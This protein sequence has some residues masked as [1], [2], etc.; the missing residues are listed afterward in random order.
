MDRIAHV[1]VHHSKRILALTAIITLIAVGM[2]F[3]MEFNADIAGSILESNEVGREFVALTEKYATSDPI[4]VIIS[5]PE[6]ERFDEPGDLALIAEAREEIGDLPNVDFA[7]SIVPEFNPLTGAPLSPESVAALPEGAVGQLIAANPLSDVFLSADGRHSLLMVTPGEAS[8]EAAQEVTEWAEGQ[9][10]ETVLSGNPIVF[11][12]VLDLISLFLLVI[13][14]AVIL[15]LLLVFYINIGNPRLAGLSIFPAIIGSLWTF[16]LI[17]GLGREVDLLTVIVPIFV[18]VMGS[19]DGL[20]FVTHFQQAEASDP[21]EKVSNALR[22]VGIPMILTTIS[23]A[24]GFLSLLATDVGPIRQLGLFTAIGI[25]FAGIVSFFSLPALIAHLDIASGEAKALIGPRLITGVKRLVSSR[26]PAMVLAL[27]LV[28]FSAVFIPQLDVDSDQLFFYKDDDPVR[29]AFERTEELFGGATPLMGEF[30]FDPSQGPGQLAEINATTEELEALPGVRRVI[31]AAALADA[32]PPEQVE[33]ILSGE[34][35]SPI[36]GLVSEDGLRFMLLPEDF[37]TDELRQWLDYAE[38]SDVVTALTGMPVV[39][40][41]I[42]RLVLNAQVTSLAVAFGLVAIMLLI[43]Y[44]RWRQT[45]V[46]L[47]PIAL[48]VATLLGFLAAS[49]IQL[50]LLTAVASSI[51][52]GVGIDYSIH[53][54]AA[55]DLARKEGP[56]YV[57]RAIDRAGKPII[58]NALG[59]AIGLSALL[60]SPLAIHA[61]VSAIMWV[62][63]TTAALS[64][65]LIIPALLPKDGIALMSDDRVSARR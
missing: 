61:Q 33:A 7:T 39:W 20:H 47:V 56:G 21:V 54:V 31:S 5:L 15:L 27:G 57:Y 14:P 60:F 12:S 4:N 28:V 30:S 11:S 53:Y 50:N 42:A 49:G 59:I 32:L 58:A 64:A 3:R 2:L 16:G 22:H 63:M 1:I 52:I 62:S 46:S 40:D 34:A 35:E 25:G 18:I 43:A 37:S 36:G 23:T 45:F 10:Y 29:V 24:V 65:L 8:L 26:A 19:A 13:P 6:G 38:A 44:R 9:S 41:E 48:T 17:F 55:I 51:V